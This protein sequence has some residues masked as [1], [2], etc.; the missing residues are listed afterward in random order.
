METHLLPSG[1][2]LEQ[3]KRVHRKKQHEAKGNMLTQRDEFIDA[4]K[5]TAAKSAALEY[6]GIDELNAALTEIGYLYCTDEHR[7]SGDSE[8][9]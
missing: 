5:E 6:E 7:K 2:Y 9:G 3:N 4:A 1:T 8:S